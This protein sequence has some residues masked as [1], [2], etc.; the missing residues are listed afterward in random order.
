VDAA[1]VGVDLV[2]DDG[3]V[4]YSFRPED[5]LNKLGSSFQ[6]VKMKAVHKILLGCDDNRIKIEILKVFLPG[7]CGTSVSAVCC[8]SAT[9]V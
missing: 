4:P 8:P 5:D 1:E 3:V 2:G 9:V 6:V 7:C